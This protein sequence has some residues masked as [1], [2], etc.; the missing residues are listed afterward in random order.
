[1]TYPT[2]GVRVRVR[3]LHSLTAGLAAT[4]LAGCGGGVGIGDGQGAD[5]VVLDVPIVY[6]QRPLPVDD[7]GNPLDSDA[8]DLLTFNIGADLYVRDRASPST[9]SRNV[10]G[11]LTQGLYDIRDLEPSWDGTRVVFAMRGPFIE[12]ADE[13]DQPTW[14]VWEYNLATDTLRRIIA[15]DVT[16]EAGHDVAPHYLPDGR[17]IFSSTRQRQSGAILVDEGKPQFP[18]LDEDRD[19]PAFV[20]HVMDSDGGNLRQVSF[21]Q[22]HDLDPTVIDTGEVVFTRWDNAGNVR[23]M[24]LY[25]M[26]PDGTNLQLLYGANSHDTGTNGATVEFLQPRQLPGG[27]IMSLLRPFTSTINGGDLIAI[28]TAQYVDNTQPLAAGIGLLTGPAQTA[29]TPN[30]VSTDGTI[31]PNGVYAGAFPLADGTGRL[32]VSWSQCRVLDTS[33]PPRPQPCTPA[34]LAAPNVEAAPPIFG[35]WVYDPAGNTQLPVVPPLEGVVFSEIV[36]LEARPPPPVIFDKASTGELDP[37]L[38]TEGVGLLRIRS[39]YDFDGAAIQ[40]IAAMADPAQTLAV[41]R[42]ARFLRLEKAVAIPDEEVRDFD[43]SAFGISSLQ[44]MREIL[45]YAMIEPDGSVAVKVPADVPVAISVL[46]EAGR[47]IMP[48]HQN[49]LQLRA[50]EVRSC[51]GCHAPA[52]GLSHGRDGVF[53]GVW[54]GATLDGQPFPNTNPALFAD[55]GETMAEARARISCATDCAAITPGVNVRFDDVWTDPVAAGRAPDASF[56][57]SYAD[58]TTPAPTSA[59]CEAAWG[60]GCRIVINYEAHI[61]PLWS[62]PRQVLDGNGAVIAD[63]TCTT[64]HNVVDANA[65]AQVPAAQLDLSNGT[66]DLR[67]EYFKSYAELFLTDNEQELNGGVLQDRFVEIGI[68]PVTGDP[69][70]APVPVAPVMNTGGAR[71]SPGFFDR[72]DA[73]G[74]HAGRLTP[75]ELRLLSEWVDLGAQYYNNPFAAPLD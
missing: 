25:K 38:L 70:L 8:T 36:A 4:V 46:D 40:D 73:G 60:P 59:A 47:R 48:R 61:H 23:E 18:G 21:N 52:S 29:L 67:P 41:D 3:F 11:A 34:R 65:A 28:D 6:V 54:A 20:L 26:N 45:G 19:E 5:P 17:I 39:V 44:G 24:S 32:L 74:T 31:S 58:L 10:T 16:A 68:D 1:M 75:A 66:S 71:A 12:D 37:D 27:R 57:Y 69:I 15:S 63:N 49:W 64:C 9:A 43:Q 53:A 13:E 30:L 2:R 50:G 56:D 42:P 33:T 72:F 51:N 62:A 35:I 7:Q 55:I 14:N 22:S